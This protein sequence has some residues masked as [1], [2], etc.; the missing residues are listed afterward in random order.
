MCQFNNFK[1]KEKILNNAKKPRD[2]GIYIYKD[3]TRQQE[4]AKTSLV[5][6][7]AVSK[8]K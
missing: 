6:S 2:T 7:T 5:E 3:F 4:F 1:D 8:T